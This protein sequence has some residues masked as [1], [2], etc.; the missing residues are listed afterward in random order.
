MIRRL[1]VPDPGH[2]FLVAD[3]SQV[4]PRIIASLSGDKVMIETYNDG[5]DVYL[6]VAERLDRPRAV[7]KEMVLS[8]AYGIGAS[9]ISERIGVSSKEAKELM[10]F[11]SSQFPAIGRHKRVVI[12]QAQRSRPKRSTTLFG[13]HRII[14]ELAS[15]DEGERARGERIAYNHVIQGTAADINKMALVRAHDMLPPGCRILLTVHDEIVVDCPEDLVDEASEALR[16]AME[17][18]TDRLVVPLVA[19]LH[20]VSDWSAAK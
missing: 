4:E 16:E 14:P 9:T 19:D 6:A 13:R 7:G 3:Y 10:E 12:Q 20:V 15:R 1:F 18:A 11:F 2:K 17:H 5:G 8:L